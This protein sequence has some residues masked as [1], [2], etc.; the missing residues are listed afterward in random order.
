MSSNPDPTKQAVEV[1]FTLTF[2]FTYYI[3]CQ[4]YIHVHRPLYF[5]NSI[6][7]Q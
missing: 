4:A 3:H 6:V 7:K 1:I 2:I 5:N